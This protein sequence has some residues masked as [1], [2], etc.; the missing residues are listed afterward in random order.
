MFE[1]VFFSQQCK[2]IKS[3]RISEVLREILF[4]LK[5]HDFTHFMLMYVLYLMYSRTV[6]CTGLNSGHI[7]HVLIRSIEKELPFLHMLIYKKLIYLRG[8]ENFSSS[9]PVRYCT[10]YCTNIKAASF[11]ANSEFVFLYTG[12][13][14]VLK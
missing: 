8:R 7:V 5:S 2:L 9:F 6:N 12:K 11:K 10:I 4:D 14:S 1:C 3:T 13:N